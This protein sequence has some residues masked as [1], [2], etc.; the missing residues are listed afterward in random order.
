[1][2]PIKKGEIEEHSI[3]IDEEVRNSLSFKLTPNDCDPVKEVKGHN[4]QQPEDAS[5]RKNLLICI[6]VSLFAI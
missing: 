2:L 1:M 5:E 4:A 6:L 3:A